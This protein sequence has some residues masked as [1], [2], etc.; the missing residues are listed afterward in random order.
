MEKFLLTKDVQNYQE[1]C[2]LR[3]QVRRLTRKAQK[4]YEK[5]IIN[6]IKQNPKKFWQY[7]QAKMATRMGIPNL[8]KSDDDKDDLTKSDSEKAQVLADYFSSVFTR[9]PEGETSEEPIRCSKTIKLCSIN[10]STVASKL[11]K[12]K[13]FKSPGPDGLHPRVLHELANG[14]CTP[15]SIIFNTSLTISV[16]P[17]YWKTANVSAIHKKGNKNQTQNYRP[18]SL[19]S[20][21]GKILE[22]I[23][24]DTVTEH[25]KDNDLLSDKQFGFIKGRSTVLQL[26]KV[27]DSWTEILENGGC[28]DVV[29]CDFMKAFDKVPHHRLI[30]KLQSYGIKGKILDWVAAMLSNRSQR[31]RVNNSFSSWQ[32]VTSGILQGSVIGPLLFVIFINDLPEV[33][34]SSELFLFADDMKLFHA[35]YTEEDC[36]S[37]QQDLI[38]AEQWTNTSLLKFHPNKCSHTRI[39][40]SNIRNDGYTLGPEHITIT[41]TDK[42]KDIGVIFDS[43]L[44]FEAHVRKNK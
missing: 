33:I 19:T 34:K 40:L 16:L 9:E 42:V 10:P 3:N 36:I 12:L 35:I 27:L 20:V 15:L 14:I 43:L 1:F 18:V 2:R 17:T 6:Q 13:T 41:S 44:N 11:K 4:Q 21:A 39:G 22:Q 7:A 37:L 25:M 30:G 23:I 8:I 28:I 24:R 5:D 31:V 29:Y 32:E 26:L 38:L